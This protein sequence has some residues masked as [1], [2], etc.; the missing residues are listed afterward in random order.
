MRKLESRESVKRALRTYSPPAFVGIVKA[1]SRGHLLTREE[2]ANDPEV[3]RMVFDNWEVRQGWGP[4]QDDVMG[5]IA[6]E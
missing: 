1:Y 2:A 4:S 6:D 3:Q 5:V